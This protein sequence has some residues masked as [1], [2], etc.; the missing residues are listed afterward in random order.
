M[1]DTSIQNGNQLN[2]V[3]FLFHPLE[4]VS[5]VNILQYFT[6]EMFLHMRA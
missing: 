5:K 2:L 3:S 4:E 6:I 1:L